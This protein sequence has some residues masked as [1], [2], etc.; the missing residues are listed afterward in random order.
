RSHRD[1]PAFPH[2]MVLTA[3]FGLSPVTGL[4]CHR[5]R[6]I[7]RVRAR[8]GRHASANLTQA[9]GLQAPTTSPSATT[10]LVSVPLIAHRPKPT[11]PSRVAQNAAAST[12]SRPASVTMANAPLWD[13]TSMDIDLIW[14]GRKQEYFCKWGW[15]A[16]SLICPSGISGPRRRACWQP[17]W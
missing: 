5:R 4:V 17:S 12:A 14:V 16:N 9:S 13:G 11:L 15:T 10:S 3:Y 8:E 2:A 6:Q 7:W 1:H